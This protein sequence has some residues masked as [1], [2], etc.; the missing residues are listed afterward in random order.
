MPEAQRLDVGSVYAELLDV[1]LPFGLVL[2]AVRV[3]G[4]GLTI[5]D[6]PLKFNLPKP[7]TLEVEIGPR[8]L[9][10][11]L[12]S[13]SP[14][15]LRNFNVLVHQGIIEITAAKK[16]IVDVKVVCTCRLRVVDGRQ[17][18]VDLET[19][20]VM[21][22]SLKNLIQSQLDEMNPVF[23][24]KDIPIPATLTSVTMDAGLI[25]IRGTVAPPQ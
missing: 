19:V 12:E 7:G 5:Q 20:E 14:G 16:V 24:A 4:N 18:W 15:G 3:R 22:G 1:K 6:S 2:D 10:A 8:S 21:G 11:F 13:K 17:I 25:T 9:A 23:D